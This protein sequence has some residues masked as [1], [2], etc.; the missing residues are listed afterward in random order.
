MHRFA[1]AIGNLEDEPA[2]AEE[3]GGE[4]F[5]ADL[6]SERKALILRGGEEARSYSS[7]RLERSSSEVI[8]TKASRSS[9]GS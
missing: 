3:G 4:S 8:D 7:M 9:V 5:L 6:G 1:A 2:A